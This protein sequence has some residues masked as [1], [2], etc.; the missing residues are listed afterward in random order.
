[1]IKELLDK[2]RIKS[3][4]TVREEKPEAIGQAE[5]ANDEV[6]KKQSNIMLFIGGVVLALMLGAIGYLQ[7]KAQIRQVAKEEKEEK[8]NVQTALDALDPDKMWRNYLEGDLRKNQKDVEER[9]NNITSTIEESE[10]KLLESTKAEIA[11]LQQQI[12]YVKTELATTIQELQ[13]ATSLLDKTDND[14]PGAEESTKIEVADI[15]TGHE[16]DRPK[17]ARFYIPETTYVSGNLLGGIAVSTGINA[18]DEHAT[19][20]VIKLT[21]RGNLP[22]NFTTDI[23]GCRILGSSYGDLSSERAIIRAEKL[24][25][26][27][28]KTELVTTSNIAGT[29][30]GSDGMNGIKGRVIATSSRHIKNAL[31][32]SIISGLSQ[33]ARGQDSYQLNSFGAV[34]TA[35]KGAGQI[36]GQGLLSGTSTAAEK[37]ADYYLRMAENMA[38]VLTVP[39]GVSVDVV[40]LKGFFIGELGTHKKIVKARLENIQQG[41]GQ[42]GADIDE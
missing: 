37:V 32:G 29:I 33:S 26:I 5:V 11:G 31:F 36:A 41:I 3:G 8:H 14:R 18:P 17:N 25:C 30:H 13:K 15:E 4:S 39:G 1:M 10:R 9:L 2:F 12:S 24:I 21:G 34:S 20:V 42:N 7:S 28:P 19:P 40:F 16:F 22:K 38:P 27:D 23:T 35:K 6:R